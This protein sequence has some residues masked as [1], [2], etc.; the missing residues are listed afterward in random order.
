MRSHCH[1]ITKLCLSFMLKQYFLTVVSHRGLRNCFFCFFTSHLLFPYSFWTFIPLFS[2]DYFFFNFF[3][4]RFQFFFISFSILFLFNRGHI[5]DFFQIFCSFNA[6]VWTCLS[7]AS[8]AVDP[9]HFFC[10]L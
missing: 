6:F 5:L 9:F 1:K 7:L 4:T 3:S 2:L 8:F 10:C